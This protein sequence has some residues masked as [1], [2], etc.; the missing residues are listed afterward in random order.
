MFLLNI[1]NAYYCTIV[2]PPPCTT[3]MYMRM[4]TR[5]SIPHAGTF[6]QPYTLLCA[7][8]VGENRHGTLQVSKMVH[9]LHYLCS[10]GLDVK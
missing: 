8:A 1:R 9:S 5:V 10:L 3:C 6:I 7:D 4:V 2:A